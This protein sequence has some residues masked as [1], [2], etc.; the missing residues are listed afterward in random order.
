MIKTGYYN[1]T[2]GQ[3]LNNIPE[4]KGIHLTATPVRCLG[5][6]IS[7]NKKERER[8]VVM[9]KSL[10]ISQ[11]VNVP[12]DIIKCINRLIYNFIWKRKDRI[13]RNVLIGYQEKGGINMVDVESKIKAVKAAWVS[14][15]SDSSNSKMSAIFRIYLK[16]I[17]INLQH[18]ALDELST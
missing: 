17:G 12:N 13:K 9:V 2:L 15:I 8:K 5:I 10:A 16:E 6:Y 1:V 7:K 4:Y 18:G 3:N 11:L 14:R